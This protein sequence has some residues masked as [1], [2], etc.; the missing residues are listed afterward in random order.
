M[1]YSAEVT[2]ID[3]YLRPVFRRMPRTSPRKKV[4]SIIGTTA[5]AAATFATAGQLIAPRSE[6]IGDA[7]KIAPQ[8]SRGVAERMKPAN[9]SRH[10]CAFRE[11]CSSFGLRTSSDRTSGQS[12]ITAAKSSA[13]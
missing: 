10:R 4:S 3:I 11:S 5:E 9:T 12:K 13:R 2:K 1:E 7:S 8:Q 6:K